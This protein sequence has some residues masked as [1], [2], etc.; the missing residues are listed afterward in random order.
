MEAQRTHFQF[1]TLW[2]Y[3]Q[4]V[5]PAYLGAY[6]PVA[7]KKKELIQIFNCIIMGQ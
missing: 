4:T 6:T 1:G 5:G 2:K 7:K 3:A